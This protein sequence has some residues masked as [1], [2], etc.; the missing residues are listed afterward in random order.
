MVCL[1][2]ATTCCDCGVDLEEEDPN[3]LDGVASN[4]NPLARHPSGP[5]TYA[6]M[7]FGKVSGDIGSGVADSN[8][9]IFEC[10]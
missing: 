7:S 10:L 8:S 5:K 2:L 1:K 6:K 3:I 4:P 9:V